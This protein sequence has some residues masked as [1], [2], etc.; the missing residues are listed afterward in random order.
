MDWIGHYF[1]NFLDKQNLLEIRC[2]RRLSRL[3]THH[4]LQIFVSSVSVLEVITVRAVVRIIVCSI[5]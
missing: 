3:S 2:L 1:I 5:Y 4:V